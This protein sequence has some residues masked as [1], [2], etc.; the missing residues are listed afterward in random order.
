MISAPCERVQEL[1]IDVLYIIHTVP[2]IVEELRNPAILLQYAR[3]LSFLSKYGFQ[4][5]KK[6]TWELLLRVPGHPD[7]LTPNGKGSFLAA[8][9]P[10]MP[11]LPA[12]YQV[13]CCKN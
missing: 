9:I 12:K 3:E 2:E 13:Y 10:S 8:V 5:P 6:G 4:G 1:K 11:T 7:N